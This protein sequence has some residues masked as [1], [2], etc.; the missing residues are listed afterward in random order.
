MPHFRRSGCGIVLYGRG[1][2]DV[3]ADGLAGK[4]SERVHIF[5]SAGV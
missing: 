1:G 3:R 5:F 4:V 2:H